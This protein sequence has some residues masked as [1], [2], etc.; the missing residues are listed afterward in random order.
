[1]LGLAFVAPLALLFRG[2]ASWPVLLAFLSLPRGVKLLNVLRSGL[3]GLPLNRV[4]GQTAQM[5]LWYSLLMAL[6]FAAI[7]I[8]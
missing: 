5:L 7:S 1:M 2:I 3:E 4:L 8:F 6:G